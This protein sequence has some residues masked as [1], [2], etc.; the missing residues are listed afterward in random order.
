MFKKLVSLLL[1]CV[2]CA[3]SVWAAKPPGTKTYNEVWI[4]ETYAYAF[5]VYKYET[6]GVEYRETWCTGV[7][8]NSTEEVI[9][10][11]LHLL[12]DADTEMDKT[13]FLAN[14]DACIAAV[15]ERLE[16]YNARRGQ[17]AD[18]AA[19]ADWMGLGETETVL[20]VQNKTDTP[21]QRPAAAAGGTVI[22]DPQRTA[23]QTEQPE[24]AEQPGCNADAG[25]ICGASYYCNA[26]RP[27]HQI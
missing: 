15:D 8:E 10:A 9:E 7:M 4:G 11:S 12:L 23:G 24:Q 27:A 16:E 22:R 17:G 21:I 3:C 13:L 25:G 20:I 2:C 18:E 5:A 14:R 26:G 1:A 6:D 19:L